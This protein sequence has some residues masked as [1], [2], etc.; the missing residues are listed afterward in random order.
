MFRTP[1]P[2]I[3]N[4]AKKEEP[5]NEATVKAKPTIS[6][7]E[8]TNLDVLEDKADPLDLE[9]EYM[10]PRAKGDQPLFNKCCQTYSHRH[11]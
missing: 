10:P 11:A 7:A 2:P 1:A 4:E 5:R 8:M 6:H 3:L 9:P